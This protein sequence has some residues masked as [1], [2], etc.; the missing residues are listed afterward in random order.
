[1]VEIITLERVI[2]FIYGSVKLRSLKILC[3]LTTE[4]INVRLT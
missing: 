3:H 1:V 4:L 2:K